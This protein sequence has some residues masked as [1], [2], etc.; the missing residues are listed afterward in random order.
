MSDLILG[1]I[2]R[3][4][5]SPHLMFR[6]QIHEF[7]RKSSLVPILLG[8]KSFVILKHDQRPFSK[9]DLPN[10]LFINGPFSECS[11]FVTNDNV[12]DMECYWSYPRIE[13]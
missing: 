3:M 11:L 1:I 12:H 4:C 2:L 9:E 7:G 8:F 6:D 5:F 10:C 13:N